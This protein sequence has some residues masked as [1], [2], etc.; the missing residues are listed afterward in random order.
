MLYNR[1]S[2]YISLNNSTT[3]RFLLSC[4]YFNCFSESLISLSY[5]CV[6]FYFLAFLCFCASISSSSISSECCPPNSSSK[7]SVPS[8]HISIT[9]T[10]YL[11]S[12]NVNTL[13]V[14]ISDLLKGILTISY[15]NYA[16]FFYIF[17]SKI[18]CVFSVSLTVFPTLSRLP[19]LKK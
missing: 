19:G 6:L 18:S 15:C 3:G 13:F 12:L 4:I 7:L 8:R 10:N 9:F 2:I 11:F 14:N 16:I 17:Y 5:T 1:S